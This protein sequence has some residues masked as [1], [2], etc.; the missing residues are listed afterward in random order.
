MIVTNS[1]ASIAI[2][3]GL[4][5]VSTPIGNLDDLTFRAVETLKSVDLI[6]AEDTRHS[7]RLLSHYSIDTPR[8]SF[9]D[10]NE[11]AVTPRLLNDLQQGRSIAVISDAGT[12]LIRDP[13]YHLVREAQAVNIDVIPVPGCCAAIAALSASG[14]ATDRFVFVGYPPRTQNARQNFLQQIVDDI[15]TVIMYESSHRVRSCLDDIS[16][17]YP[18][19]RTIVVAREITKQHES[20]RSIKV[21]EI[22]SFFEDSIYADKGEFVIVLQGK[23]SKSSKLELDTQTQEMLSLLLTEC[24]VKTAVDLT[25][26]LSG[27]SKKLIYQAALEIQKQA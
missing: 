4:Y 25:T 13:G 22:E 2:A 23:N 10:H 8:I 18:P 20:I 17:I 9:H 14:L 27:A 12:P 1:E 11:D 5:L 7:H 19:S 21:S 3:P 24:S 26:K 6:A 16:N 15:G